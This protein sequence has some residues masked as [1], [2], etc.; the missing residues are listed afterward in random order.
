[1]GSLSV[2]TKKFQLA[3]KEIIDI[4]GSVI[5]LV[6]LSPLFLVVAILIKVDSKGSVF[7]MQERVG[8]DGKLFK[9]WKFRTMSVKA[10]ANGFGYSVTPNNPYLTRI[11]R[12]LRGWSLDELP[13]LINVLRREMSLVGPRPVPKWQV[14]RY[15][16]V[17]R[18]RLS[19]KPGITGWGLIHGRNLLPW[20]KRI[21]LDLWYVKHW[22]LWL[23]IRI[24][25][26]TLWIVFV[27]KE[28]LYGTGE[29]I[30]L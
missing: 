6:I 27:T 15:T 19:V 12:F 26:K 23:D 28:G 14:E 20:S 29:R 9:I 30:D 13:Q 3:L 10:P 7:F 25:F 18:V 4:V 8:K 24:L 2:R 11:G 16:D 17:Q 1:M 22:S 21:E 5:G